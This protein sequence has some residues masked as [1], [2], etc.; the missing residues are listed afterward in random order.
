MLELL[1]VDILFAI[2]AGSGSAS[3]AMVGSA[4]HARF[5]REPFEVASKIEATLEAKEWCNSATMS[6]IIRLI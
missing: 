4:V 3:K 5:E 1:T 2:T 6:Q